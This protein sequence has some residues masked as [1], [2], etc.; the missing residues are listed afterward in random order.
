MKK[1]GKC[2]E[3]KELTEFYKHKG[4]KCGVSSAC[5]SCSKKYW[6]SDRGKQARV[7]FD[8]SN[9]GKKTH[10]NWNN[11]WGSGVYQMISDNQCLY[12][13]CSKMLRK[14]VSDHKSYIKNPKASPQTWKEFYIK[15]QSHS[16][17][18]F[19]I[20]EVCDDYKEKEKQYINQLKPKYN[21]T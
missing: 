16:N 6:N 19:K 15:L 9:K 5:K 14:R 10:I 4:G 13:G 11:S 12:V 3:T 17:I 20:V 2:Q 7:R 21:A 18:E 8:A 1:C